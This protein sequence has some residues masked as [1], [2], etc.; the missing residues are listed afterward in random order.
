MNNCYYLNTGVGGT[1]RGTLSE[2]YPE[3]TLHCGN[4]IV[5]KSN[6]DL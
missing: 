1:E 3:M 6:P 5:K 2:E 4:S